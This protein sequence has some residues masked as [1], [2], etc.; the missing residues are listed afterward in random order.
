MWGY[1][2]FLV[3]G[4]AAAIGSGIEVAVEESVGQAHL[5][6]FAASAS[7]TV[8]SALFMFSVWLIHSRHQKRGPAQQLNLP[9]ASVL[10]LLCTCAGHWAVP[11]AGTVAALSVVVGAVLT[12]R[13]GAALT[14]SE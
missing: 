10:V 11:L 7:V 5:S 8:P 9:V 1:G 6:T 13:R 2:N 14:D 4:S 12:A 3:L